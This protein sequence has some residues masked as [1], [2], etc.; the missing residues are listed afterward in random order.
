MQIRYNAGF[1]NLELVENFKVE[2]RMKESSN[3]DVRYSNKEV[4]RTWIA[5]YFNQGSRTVTIG[6]TN[7]KIAEVLD[8]IHECI[9]RNDVVCDIRKY[10]I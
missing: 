1:I 3:S 4:E 6:N 10:E 5:F 7:D 2:Q 8:Y 9:V